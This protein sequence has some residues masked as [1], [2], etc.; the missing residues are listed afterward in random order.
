MHDQP[1]TAEADGTQWHR[2][3]SADSIALRDPLAELLGMVEAGEPLVFSFAEVAKAAGHAC[4]AVAGAYRATQ[5]AL[6]ELYPDAYPVRS[7]VRV[8]VDGDPSD[9]GLGPMASVVTH[10][11]GADGETGFAGFGGYGG[12]ENLLAFGDVDGRDEGRTFEF[13]RTDAGDPVR[14]TFS[15]AATGT[16]PPGGDDDAANL[17]PE[18]VSGEATREERHRFYDAWHGRIDAILAAEPGDGSPFSLER[19]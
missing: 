13:E 18:L 7:D 6:G 4:P 8:T 2:R 12:R 14:V 11:T 10:L 9:P 1:P 17:I 5:L 19:P 16:A 15:P 3:A